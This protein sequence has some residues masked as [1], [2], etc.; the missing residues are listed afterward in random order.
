[1]GVNERALRECGEAGVQEGFW[2]VVDPAV[3]QWVSERARDFREEEDDLGGGIVTRGPDVSSTGIDRSSRGF[4]KPT[5]Q[6][7]RCDSHTHRLTCA[8]KP[9][10]AGP[11]NADVRAHPRRSGC[12]CTGACSDTQ[13]STHVQT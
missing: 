5:V 4:S 7:Y 8:Y 2:E 10:H 13:R 11:G 6:G 9:V 1:M 12:A 3:A